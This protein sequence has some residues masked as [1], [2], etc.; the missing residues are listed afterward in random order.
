MKKNWAILSNRTKRF[1]IVAIIFY[2]LAIWEMISSSSL[3]PGMTW[4]NLGTVFL[5]LGTVIRNRENRQEKN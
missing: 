3:H 1:Y 5:C 2:G 4:L